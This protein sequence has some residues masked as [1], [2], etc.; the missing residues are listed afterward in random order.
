MKASEKV[1]LA[2]GS[3][4]KAATAPSTAEK[5]LKQRRNSNPTESKETKETS[6]KI[7][8]KKIEEYLE[9]FYSPDNFKGLIK[10]PADIMLLFT[11]DKVWNIDDKEARALAINASNAA[12]QFGFVNI[13]WIALAMF[14]VSLSTSYGTRTALYLQNRRDKKR[15]SKTE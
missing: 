14:A 3:S 7:S 10:A 11:G 2:G 15:A 5:I 4:N 9:Q 8:Q 12:R 13:K 1:V 6:E